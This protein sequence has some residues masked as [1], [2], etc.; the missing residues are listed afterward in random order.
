MSL[1]E[2]VNQINPPVHIRIKPTNICNH[3]C[4]YCAY[5]DGATKSFGKDAV[6]RTYI[7]KEKMMEIIDDLI[8]MRVKAV[9]FSGGG[10]P[11]MYPYLLDVV[12]KLADSPIRFATLTNGSLLKGEIAEIFAECGT[13]LRVSMDGWD[14]E[15]YSFYRGVPKGSFS[16]LMTNM[17]NFKKS[18][19]RCYLGVS[20]IIDE[21]NAPL[22]YQFLKKIKDV[23]V[24][25][26][27][28]SACL[29][30]DNGSE[31]TSYHKPLLHRV[32][33]QIQRAMEDLRE[34][35]FEIFDAYNALDDKFEKTY[36][37]CPYLQILPVIGADLNIYACPDKAYNLGKGLLGSIKR[38]SFKDF[39]FSDKKKFFKIN[40]SL[41]CGHH[42]E[43]NHKN[44]LVI[45]YLD[46]DREHLY[47]V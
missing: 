12:K 24:D 23:G 30:S 19:S 33:D 41:D 47:F 15:S 10:E 27:K 42:C 14:D 40:P 43:A 1:P 31:N 13:W 21:H 8:D 16:K 25:S 35:T 3:R 5:R 46:A 9:T 39:W 18:G 22:V 44:R 7:Q 34:E 20:Y 29:V 32:K 45:E 11:F 6:Q 17:A 36:T 26:V 4:R 28:L 38:Q 2:A 37:W